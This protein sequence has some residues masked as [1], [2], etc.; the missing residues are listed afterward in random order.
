MS[1]IHE[2]GDGIM[3]LKSVLL[4]NIKR[5]KN[6]ITIEL[7][8][9]SFLNTISGKNGSGKSTIFESI[10][11]VQKAFFADLLE[12]SGVVNIDLLTN[13][14]PT[15]RQRVARELATLASDREASIEITLCFSKT[16]LS[17][18]EYPLTG[19]E[20]MEV[21]LILDGS[22]ITGSNCDWT[23]RV[24]TDSE[25]EV[26]SKFWNLQNPTNIIVL[27]NADKN[28]YEEDFG[29][30]KINL[31]ASKNSS[32]IIDFVMDSK[33][34]YQ[35][36]YD[37]MMN[38]YLYQRLNPLQPR[39]DDFVAK[40][41]LMFSEIMDG[42]SISNF[43]GKSI[44]NQ[45]IL[46]A[47]NTLPARKNVTYDARNLSSGEKLIWYVILVLNY[48]KNIGLL[49][50]DEPENHL[51]EQLAWNFVRFIQSI[52][53]KEDHP[54]SVGQVFLITHAK[55][56]IYNNF[57]IGT[58]YIANESGLTQVNKEDCE[59]VLRSC[60]IS[61][62]ED[63]VLF[64]EGRT[65]NENLAKLCDQH[66]IKVKVVGTCNEIL[67]IYSSLIKV[68]ELVT[69]P[70]YIFMLDRDTRD[71][72]KIRKLRNE[73]PSYFDEHMMFLPVHE[74]ENFLLDEHVISGILNHYLQDC[75]NEQVDPISIS[76]KMKEVAD[77][78][79]ELTRKKYLNYELDYAIKGMA[80]QVNQKDIAVTSKADFTS[81][82]SNILS[83]DTIA[84]FLVQ[85]EQ[86]YDTMEQKY[87]ND[88]WN[89][90][91]KELCD[92]KVVFQKTCSYLGS[93]YRM[94]TGMLKN[95]I[96]NAIIKNPSSQFAA[97]W[98]SILEKLQ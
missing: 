85:M 52:A 37:I 45:F 41:M 89:S 3:F 30:E 9:S 88:N 13:S 80:K 36:M 17:K 74:I 2:L 12:P 40:S 4:N 50:I 75:S 98:S 43:S 71:D 58:N 73:D 81:Y 51:H 78:S 67:Q 39:R 25:K 60:G 1:K 38:A 14:Q 5:Y 61:F 87:N 33:N 84:A 63:K 44:E 59:A 65:E 77:A 31:I 16:D 91:W 20:D 29:Y 35:H 57:A 96:F 56:L 26:L 70:K 48:L 82:V 11:L 27:L 93:K 66:N 19:P 76:Q 47:K 15:H 54:I 21:S 94:D 42:V 46:L 24:N 95:K 92:G 23:I 90:Q 6:P 10:M 22:N 28:V 18:V 34:I 72:D 55:S 64:V 97:F 32:P 49:I 53:E 7:R 83:T 8:N 69:V 62:V 79:L 86:K 68:R